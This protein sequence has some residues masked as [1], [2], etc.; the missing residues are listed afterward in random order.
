MR[1][2]EKSFTNQAHACMERFRGVLVFTTNLDYQGLDSAAIWRFSVKLRIEY[3]T[4]DDNEVFYRQLLGELCTAPM[5][6][7]ERA[8]LRAIRNLA[9]WDYKTVREQFIF[10]LPEDVTHAGLVA[11]LADEA[12]IKGGGEDR[13][14][15]YSFRNVCSFG[16][17]KPLVH[18]SL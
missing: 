17:Y 9:P 11:A 13:R 5:G 7:Q 2:W 12:R 15:G 16:L 4:D 8:A 1:S 10:E 18:I 3:L 14:A 6:T